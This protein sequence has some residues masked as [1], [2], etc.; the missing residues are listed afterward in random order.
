MGGAFSFSTVFH[1]SGTVD[2]PDCRSVRTSFLVSLRT[3][4]GEK[5]AAVS[6]AVFFFENS[7][8]SGSSPVAGLLSDPLELELVVFLL[9]PDR[10]VFPSHYASGTASFK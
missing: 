5:E 4:Y 10:R 9:W 2:P 7:L 3:L 1:R 6:S 8:G